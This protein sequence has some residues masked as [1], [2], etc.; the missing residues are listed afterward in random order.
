MTGKVCSDF[1][2]APG[3]VFVAHYPPGCDGIPVALPVSWED[4]SAYSPIICCR[5][6]SR[7]AVVVGHCYPY[8]DD[9]CLCEKHLRERKNPNE[10]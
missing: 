6:C 3:T 1:R 10:H 4:V 8:S 7:P 9:G 5:L 2:A